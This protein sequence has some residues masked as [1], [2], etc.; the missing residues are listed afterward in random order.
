MIVEPFEGMTDTEVDAWLLRLAD[1]PTTADAIR[2][3]T[4]PDRWEL[5]SLAAEHFAAVVTLS[6]VERMTS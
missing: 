2:A 5:A 6:D 4:S 3:M 1:S